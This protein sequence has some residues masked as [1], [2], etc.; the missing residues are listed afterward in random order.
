M[1]P[2]LQHSS[3]WSW[4]LGPQLVLHNPLIHSSNLLTLKVWAMLV[5][6][7]E[8]Y[9]QVFL[10]HIGHT[11]HALQIVAEWMAYWQGPCLCGVGGENNKKKG[12]NKQRNTQSHT[13]YLTGVTEVSC[14]H[15]LFGPGEFTVWPQWTYYRCQRLQVWSLVGQ[16]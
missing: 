16:A 4:R 13:D 11:A 10:A 12:N 6:D 5:L 14:P 1:R 8:Q 15:L 9:T 3:A 2:Y 7:R